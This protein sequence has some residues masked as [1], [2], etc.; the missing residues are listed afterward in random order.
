MKILF[1]TSSNLVLMGG[2][3][4][5]FASSA[6]LY[7]E[8]AD[9]HVL[10]NTINTNQ[11]KKQGFSKEIKFFLSESNNN[12]DKISGICNLDKKYNYD[13]IIL[14]GELLNKEFSLKKP[15]L[16]SSKVVSY[17]TNENLGV[18]NNLELFNSS[19]MVRF[20]TE[21]HLE[22]YLNKGMEQRNYFVEYPTVID[23][24]DLILKKEYDMIY[25]G[26]IAPGWKVDKF[27]K[28]AMRYP[29]KKFCIVYSSK[30]KNLNS[31]HLAIID[32][33]LQHL[34]NVDVFHMISRE[35]TLELTSKSKYSYCYR[36]KEIDNDNSKELSTKMIEAI[37]VGSYPILRKTKM[38][39]RILGNDYPFFIENIEDFKFEDKKID[40]FRDLSKPYTQKNVALNIKKYFNLNPNIQKYITLVEKPTLS[41]VINLKLLGYSVAT[42]KKE[43]I[44]YFYKL[45]IPTLK[46]EKKYKFHEITSEDFNKNSTQYT[47]KDNVVIVPQ[48]QILLIEN[49]LSNLKDIK[50]VEEG[51]YNLGID[52][53]NVL[54]NT[55]FTFNVKTNK[56]FITALNI[57][58]KIE[59]PEIKFNIN[60]NILTK[61]FKTPGI[62]FNNSKDNEITLELCNYSLENLV[63][64]SKGNNVEV[65][66]FNMSDLVIVN[67]IYPSYN[68]LY[69]HAFVHTRVK[70]YKENNVFPT[71][72]I[73]AKTDTEVET[74]FY[75]NQL[76]IKCNGHGYKK[77]FY[78]NDNYRYA[79]H[80]VN[81]YIYSVLNAYSLTNE[82]TVW[83]HGSD[84]LSADKKEHF[85]DL[86]NAK[87]KTSFERRKKEMDVQDGVLNRIFANQTY[88]SVFVS[89]WLQ[90]TILEDYTL[91]KNTYQV[92]PNSINTSTFYYEEKKVN[93][94]EKVK[95]LS[96]MPFLLEYDQY[97]NK[98]LVE[99][100]KLASKEEWFE[101][102][103]FTIYGRG[104]GFGYY[105][106][107]LNEVS[108][109]N[110]R[111]YETFL[112]HD[113]IKKLHSEHHV[114]LFPNNQDT[115]G[116]SF[117]EAMSSG[118]LSISS[119][120]SAK[121]EYCKSGITGFLHKDQ[122]A[123]DLKEIIE[124]CCLYYND[125]SGIRKAGHKSVVEQFDE[126]KVTKMELDVVFRK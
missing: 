37:N 71:V 39:K 73:I 40:N 58:G 45:D 4:I 38:T 1:A 69:A 126:K 8:F 34:K 65:E 82:K 122:D 85:Y 90:N 63:D 57:I 72:I 70:L 16:F 49:L 86:S 97:A 96:I 32:Y 67:N 33:G 30:F 28:L 76:V 116:V 93:N 29:E 19:K 22:F 24:S 75:D 47:C 108:K 46:K 102:C 91:E 53:L 51:K 104:S 89:K 64:L 118:L 124:K 66:K 78:G 59:I 105:T 20:Q 7:C 61:G 79:I 54:L 83:F 10:S 103:E 48:K 80:F 60:T 115:H 81:K 36:S 41:Q 68:N 12:D 110:I 55:T 26:K 120:N 123:E 101:K 11:L 13:Y 23:N 17:I 125:L 84:C 95:F 121:P 113:E 21:E 106:N 43:L 52:D 9:V 100:I 62:E 107:Q 87:M 42:D 27:F 98:V 35:K 92:I 3:T 14:R 74:Y 2:D 88:K 119:N 31:N 25:A 111:C 15:A 77:L 56:E 50:I 117:Y 94:N 5:Q 6:S 18:E 112:T 109:G 44:E 99:A 114:A